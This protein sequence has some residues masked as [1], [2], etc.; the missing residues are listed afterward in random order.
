M[1]KRLLRRILPIFLLFFLII[2]VRPVYG[3]VIH[4]TEKR[5]ESPSSRMRGTDYIP[6]ILA[7]QAFGVD[8]DWDPTTRKITLIKGA[9]SLIL[10]AGSDTYL[11]DRQVLHLR[12]PVEISEEII[13]IPRGFID[14]DWWQEPVIAMEITHR[15]DTVVIDAGHGGKDPGAV[16]RS[17]LKEK[18]VVLD[19]ALYL[20]TLLDRSGIKAIL[21]RQDDRFLTLGQ[22]V[23][24]SNQHKAN[25]FVSIHVNGHRDRRA[26]GFEVW[27]LSNAKDSYSR[28]VAA[29]ENFALEIGKENFSKNTDI[30]KNLT[31]GDLQLTE[32]RVES[33]ELA[34]EICRQLG[35]QTCSRNRGIK[36]A[37][38]Y[39]LG[40][41][42]PAVLVELG[43]I[44]NFT[45]ESRLKKTSYRRK[46]A[47]A[48]CDGI[49]VY[50]QRFD[51]SNGFSK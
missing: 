48:L 23:R 49:M 39:V 27:Y 21:T 19:V 44:S 11:Q 9:G 29:T 17:G 5:V 14:L 47:R 3:F 4:G 51:Q 2:A 42:V 37:G 22:R 33:I 25:L 30:T 10:I 15:I 6:L 36:C 20:K 41:E 35:D 16:G 12:K 18:D 50:K 31:L 38:F 1:T 7:C 46:L 43:F 40:V 45:E 8:Y 26:N 13:L 32:N 34:G 24:F 28:K